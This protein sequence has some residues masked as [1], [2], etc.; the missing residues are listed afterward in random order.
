MLIGFEHLLLGA[1]GAGSLAM[2]ASKI[3]GTLR[4]VTSKLNRIAEVMRRDV[5]RP[6]WIVN[7]WDPKTVPTLTWDALEFADLEKIVD[8][9]SKLLTAAAVEPG[10]ADALVEKILAN[11]GLPPLTARDDEEVMLRRREEA[12]AAAGLGKKPA[13]G[14]EPDV[15]DPDEEDDA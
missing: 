12:Q 14:D 7:G 4:I 13:A 5:L 11:Q 3:A 15:E 1:D 8:S 10:R 2:H 9:I 6:L